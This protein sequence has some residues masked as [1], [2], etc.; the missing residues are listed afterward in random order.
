MIRGETFTGDGALS[1][2]AERTEEK[3]DKQRSELRR[4]SFA[5]SV[6]P[7]AGAKEARHH[8]RLRAGRPDHEGP[9]AE[10]EKQA[11][12]ITITAARSQQ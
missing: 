6:Q 2:H 5:R 7:P 4:G 10:V 3:E 11:R 1:V 9:P 8:R 12:K